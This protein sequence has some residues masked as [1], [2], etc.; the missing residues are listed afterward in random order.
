MSVFLKKDPLS[1][2]RVLMQSHF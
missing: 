1:W 2:H